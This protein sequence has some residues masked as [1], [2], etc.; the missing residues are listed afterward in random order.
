MTIPPLPL[1]LLNDRLAVCRLDPND[2]IPAWATGHEF[3]SITRTA[4]ELSVVCSEA[5]DAPSRG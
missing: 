3:F 4:D 2:A 1:I 5:G